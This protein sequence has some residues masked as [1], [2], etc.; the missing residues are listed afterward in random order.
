MLSAFPGRVTVVKDD[1]V[2]VYMSPAMKEIH[3]DLV[4]KRCFETSLASE[5]ICRNCPVSRGLDA[6][7]F[8]YPRV[9]RRQDG[10][11]LELSV[12]RFEDDETGETYYVSFERD[13]TE[14]SAKEQFFENIRSSFDQLPEA[15]AVIDPGGRIVYTNRAFEELMDVKTDDVSGLD[16]T[17]SENAFGLDLR[18]VMKESVESGWSGIKPLRRRDG[19]ESIVYIGTTPVKDGRGQLL[20]V[21]GVFRNVTREQ[22]EK[23]EFENYRSQLEMKMELRTAELARRVSQLTTINKISRVVT[24]ILDPDE[25]MREFSR[26]I[27]TGFGYQHVVIMAMDKERGELHFKSGYGSKLSQVPPD[28]RMKLKEGIIGH[29]AFF[30]ETLVTGDVDAD[31]RYVSRGLRTT[32]SELAIPILF[33][34]DLIGVL[35]V[36]SDVKDAFTRNDVTLLEMLTDILATAVVN[37][38]TF[39]ESKE[40]EHALTVLD[41]ISKQISFRQEPEVILDQVARDA[42]S[43]LKAEKAMVGLKDDLTGSLHWVAA[44]N[45]DREILEKLEFS[46]AKGV[47]GR[48]LSRLKAEVVNDYMSDPDARPR[49]AEIFKIRSIVSA[50]L[51]IEGR[52]IGVV[53][54][55]N[56]LNGVK[57]GK[58]DAVFL[59]SLADHAAIALENSNL[60]TSLNQRV[61]SQLALLETALSMQRQ[62]DSGATYEYVADKL[63][64]VVWYDS[65]TFYRI[66]QEK[67]LLVPTLARGSYSDKVMQEVF[68]LGVGVTGHVARTGKAELVNDT[69][70]DSRASQ[71]SGTPDEPE[72]MMAIPLRGRERMIGVLTIY[73][74]GGKTFSPADFEIAQLF[75]SQA[76]VAVENSELYRMEEM[77]LRESRTK[78]AQMSHVLA[79][80]TSVMYMDDIDTLLERLVNTVVSSFGFRRA[81]VS[82]LDFE[83]NTFVNRA[84]AGFPDWVKLG[85]IIPAEKALED[86]RDEFRI[87][88]TTYYVKYED[89]DYGIEAF[90][91]IAHPELANKPRSAPDAWHERDILIFV[92]KDRSGR[93]IGYLSV[94]EP[95]DLKMPRTEQVEMLE[96]L[97]GI[98]SIAL[99]NSRL[100]ERQVMAVNEIALLNDLMTHDINNFNQGIMGYIELLLMDERLDEA[101]KRY[102]DKALVQVRNNAR[103]IDNIRKLAKV[104]AMS[105]DDFTI[106][107]LH[108]PVAE[109]VKAVSRSTSDRSVL[110]VSSLAR[111]AHYVKANQYIGDLFVNIISNAAK[112]DGGKKVRVDVSIDEVKDSRGEFWVVSVSD[113]GRGIP[114]DRKQTVFERFATGMT[115][116]KGFGLG[117][118]I[119]ITIVEKFQGRIWVEDRVRGD[120]SK[121]SVFKVMLPKARPPEDG[122]RPD[123][124]GVSASS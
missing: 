122:G 82:L 80:T 3:G 118:S 28:V 119:V 94:D 37:A 62:M 124:K 96:I 38:R 111:D 52:G 50:P 49:D 59:S 121:G 108:D 45:T 16:I 17:T 85:E 32:K 26:S 9:A 34:G 40:R 109:A 66:E 43:L 76:A 102:A 91:F 92:L 22:S 57:F 12:S 15:V 48:A 55:Y 33:R 23:A 29:A 8:P 18:Q 7:S 27:A 105:D 63:R 30:S 25:L 116:I 61:R 104:R 114:E 11:M 13:I 1:R 70:V 53:N 58:N 21:V 36:Q 106:W 86:M 123:A 20:G 56:K 73:R 51:M 101:Q 68:P 54:V 83:S 14:Q 93:L 44:Y 120:F 90:D 100:Y 88:D 41:R 69:T 72:A 46:A 6:S 35:D 78:V 115:G 42:A 89:Q 31:P 97:A 110:V 74:E 77:L 24:S 103:V 19:S 98:A 65:I 71:V 2:I 99:E 84:L 79:L 67:D 112:F 117:L 39:T 87:G 60:L 95:V 47:T 10:P 5:D 64:E 113:R 107:D 75:A 4:G 81:S